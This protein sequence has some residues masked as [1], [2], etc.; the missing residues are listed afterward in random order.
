MILLVAASERG[1]AQ[2]MGAEWPAGLCFGGV[3]GPGSEYCSVRRELPTVMLAECPWKGRPERV[4]A[5]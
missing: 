1:G 4:T 5:P 2:T 3:V